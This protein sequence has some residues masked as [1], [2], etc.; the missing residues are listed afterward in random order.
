VS[1]L[2]WWKGCRLNIFHLCLVE[3]RKV[4]WTLIFFSF[5]LHRQ[6]WSVVLK[7]ACSGTWI[8]SRQWLLLLQKNKH[9]ILETRTEFTVNIILFFEEILPSSGQR[10]WWWESPCK[11]AWFYTAN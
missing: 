7:S 5:F 10:T 11:N 2:G 1:L 3:S 6:K 9:Y 4:L 8:L